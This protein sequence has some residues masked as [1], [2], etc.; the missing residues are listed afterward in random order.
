MLTKF[1][2]DIL[3]WF[4]KLNPTC[5]NLMLRYNAYAVEKLWKKHGSRVISGT[6]IKIIE[7]R[8]TASTVYKLMNIPVM[9]CDFAIVLF[10]RKNMQI[11]PVI[12]TTFVADDTMTDVQRAILVHEGA[13]IDDAMLD[14]SIL[15]DLEKAELSADRRAAAVL[16]HAKYAELI[17]PMLVAAAHEQ[18]TARQFDVARTNVKRLHQLA[19]W[20][21]TI[22]F[23][24]I[25]AAIEAAFT[26]KIAEDE[27]SA[28]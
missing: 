7:D 9:E 22:D 4:S 26:G 3:V 6:S 11:H 1:Y 14:I 20:S 13:H 28:K 24:T 2:H 27:H 19:E 25:D 12:Y 15:Q 16:G 18:I 5:E 10:Y 17:A 23:T 21:D 8:K